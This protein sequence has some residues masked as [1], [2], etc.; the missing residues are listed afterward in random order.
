MDA[1]LPG[2]GGGVNACLGACQ[3][4]DDSAVLGT[5]GLGRR[6]ARGQLHTRLVLQHFHLASTIAVLL[7]ML[8]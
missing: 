7:F 8:G 6:N 2:L 4:G 3:N 5:S 1:N